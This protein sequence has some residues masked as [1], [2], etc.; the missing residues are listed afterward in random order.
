ME[1]RFSAIRAAIGTAK[2]GDMVVLLGQVGLAICT[3]SSCN[4]VLR[5]RL[6]NIG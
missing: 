5:P 2:P 6:L 3:L 4:L 1:D